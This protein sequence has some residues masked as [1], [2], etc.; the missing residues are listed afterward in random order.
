MEFVIVIAVIAFIALAILG[1]MQASKRRKELAAWAASRGLTYREAKDHNFMNRFPEFS[2]LRAGEKNRF[3]FNIINGSL[4]QRPVVCFDYH[5]QT[6]STDSKGRRQTHTHYFSGLIVQAPW[7]LKPLFIRPEGFFDKITEFFGYDDIDFESA[8]FSRKFYVKSP[9]KK[10]AFDVLHQR[11]MEFLLGQPRF[12]IEM[13]GQ[14]ILAYRGKTFAI[15][16]FEAAHRV[17]D[18]LLDQ[19]PEYVR[20]EIAGQ[21]A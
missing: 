21:G 20:R 16:D 7:A 4:D 5:Y 6:T 19:L 18:G 11:A 9:D 1:A 15:P 13:A 2:C 17:I 14:R 8:E 3:A 12:T 10:W